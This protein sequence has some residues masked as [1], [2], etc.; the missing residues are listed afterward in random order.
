MDASRNTTT[1]PGCVGDADKCDVDPPCKD[2]DEINTWLGNKK[3]AGK[4]LTTK[5]N[6]AQKLDIKDG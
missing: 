1:I 4:V 2:M 6:F 3:I 5:P